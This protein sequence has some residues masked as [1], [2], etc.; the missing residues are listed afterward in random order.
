MTTKEWESELKEILDFK[1]AL[2]E[3]IDHNKKEV[4]RLNALAEK[5]KDPTTKANIYR[6][7]RRGEAIISTQITKRTKLSGE[8]IARQL[9]IKYHVVR[10]K[11]RVYSGRRL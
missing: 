4:A 2:N 8:K 6:S 1:I 11:E 3:K 9:G 7:V 10:Y 5:E